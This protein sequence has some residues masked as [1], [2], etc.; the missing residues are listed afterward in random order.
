MC[1]IYGV[2]LSVGAPVLIDVLT[3]D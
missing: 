1:C 3:G 2:L